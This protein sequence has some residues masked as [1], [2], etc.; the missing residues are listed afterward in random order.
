[1][2]RKQARPGSNYPS[3]VFIRHSH[4]CVDSIA[5]FHQQVL[6]IGPMT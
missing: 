6:Q 2:L 3:G 4:S 1:V 5:P